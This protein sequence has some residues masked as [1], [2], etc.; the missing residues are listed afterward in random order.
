M[1]E[2]MR[3]LERAARYP[4]RHSGPLPPEPATHVAI[5]SCMD[6]RIDPWELFGLS[7]GDAHVLRNAGGVVTDDILRSLSVSQHMLGTRMVL[8]V[9]HTRCGMTTI[10]DEEFAARLEADAGVRPPWQVGCF[11]D[12]EESV[13]TSVERVCDSPFVPYRDQVFGFVFDVDTGHVHRVHR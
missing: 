4:E 10:T 6:A 7:R 1:D 8:I 5:V 11:A 3:L 12:L 13:R 2:V 9:Q